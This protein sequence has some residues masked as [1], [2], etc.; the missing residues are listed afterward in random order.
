MRRIKLIKTCDRFPE[1]YDAKYKGKQVG[2]LRYRHGHFTAEF[3]DACG[4]LLYGRDFETSE[5]WNSGAFVTEKERRTYL[6]LAK[7]L[8]SD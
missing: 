7:E 8:I 5:G 3:P 4:R 2:Y 6:K 1:Q